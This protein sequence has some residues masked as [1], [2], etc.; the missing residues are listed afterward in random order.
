MQP[1][2]L[3]RLLA[4]PHYKLSPK[5]EQLSKRIVYGA[6]PIHPQGFATHPKLRKEAQGHHEKQNG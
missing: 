5:D 2:T 4:N 1:S 3:Q 6:V